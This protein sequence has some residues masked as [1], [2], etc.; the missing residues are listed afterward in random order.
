MNKIITKSFEQWYAEEVEIAFDLERVKVKKIPLLEELISDENI[1]LE[2]TANVYKLQNSLIDNVDSWNEDELK[3]Q[4]LGPLLVESDFNNYPYYKV[5]SQRKASIQ[6]EKVES[7]GKIEWMVAQGR[8]IPRNPFFFLHEYK[9]EKASGNDP[10]GQ[11]LMAMVYA[12][13]E[14]QNPIFGTYILGRF[15]FFTVLENQKYAVSN[16]YN[17]TKTEDLAII[18]SVLEKVKQHIHQFLQL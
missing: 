4:F 13:K 9:G 15:W 2:L 17:A 18:L 14:N 12:Q 6:T 16:A 1:N 11:L 7:S 8:Q 10:L 3:M 5:F